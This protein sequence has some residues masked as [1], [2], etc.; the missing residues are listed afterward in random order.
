MK[1]V[2][3]QERCLPI[4]AV[5]LEGAT[6]PTQI[7][8]RGKNTKYSISFGLYPN[9]ARLPTPITASSIAK[10]LELSAVNGVY[11]LQDQ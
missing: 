3:S 4:E 7:Y 6:V 5:S 10:C 9:E 11:A 1:S 2:V 8:T